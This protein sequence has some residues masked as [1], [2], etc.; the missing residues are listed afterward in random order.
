MISPFRFGRIV[1]DEAFTNRTADITRLKL[2][3]QNHINTV[4]ISP[5]R[6]GKSSLVKKVVSEIKSRNIIIIELDLLGLKNNGDFYNLIATE[7]IKATSNKLDEW[8]STSKQFFRNLTP[9]ISLGTDPLQEFSL[10]FEWNETEK[11]YKELLDLPDQLAKRKNL[12]I[13]FCIDEFQNIAEFKDADLT[14]KRLRS[15]WQH[16]QNVTYCLYGSKQHMM[17]QLFKK[18]SNPLY[19]FG[20]VLYLQ[21]IARA[22]WVAFIKENFKKTQKSISDNLAEKIAAITADHS[23]YVQQLAYITWSNTT[24]SVTEEI[25]NISKDSLLNQNAMLYIR[26]TEDLTSNQLNLLK[27]VASGHYK[28]LSSKTIIDRFSLGTSANVLKL[29]NSLIQKELIDETV[30]GIDFIDPIYKLWFEKNIL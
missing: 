9:K 22:E 14:F 3:L 2:N 12:H 15:A 5:R 7:T 25:L 4:L 24:K 19:K 30:Q 8:I 1:S 13:I 28:G 23:Y 16:H 18:Q 27:A 10:S 29:K 21:K 11:H 20:E 17:T 26:D 6:W